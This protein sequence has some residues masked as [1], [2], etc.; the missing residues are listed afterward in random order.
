MSTLRFLQRTS[1]KKT[2]GHRTGTQHHE[3][4]RRSRVNTKGPSSDN[5]SHQLK[6]PQE[7]QGND[8]THNTTKGKEPHNTANQQHRAST[9]LCVPAKKCEELETLSSRAST[10]KR[11]PATTLRTGPKTEKHLQRTL[12]LQQF[13]P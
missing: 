3:G 10:R 13:G 7:D 5:E 6:R 12:H 9:T 8:E 2:Q 1:I 4:R 11:P